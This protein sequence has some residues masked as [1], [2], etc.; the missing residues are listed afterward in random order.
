MAEVAPRERAPD[1]G[2]SYDGV[3][4]DDIGGADAVRDLVER[5]YDLMDRLPEAREIRAMHKGD[6]GEMREKLFEFLSGWLGGPPLFFERRGPSCIRS[7]HAI[8]PIDESARDQWLLCMSRALDEIQVEAPVRELLD[9]A[10][11][12]MADM[13]RTDTQRGAASSA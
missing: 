2:V 6:L 1:D 3:P 9:Q 11:W 5:F 4:Y 12:R 7:A 13:L 8:F 10:F